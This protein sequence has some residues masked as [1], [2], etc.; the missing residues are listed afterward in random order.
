MDFRFSDEQEM[1]AGVVR[2]LLADLCQ[3]ADLRRLMTSGEARDAQRWASLVELGLAGAQV[4]EAAGGLG[5]QQVDMVL[6]AE[7]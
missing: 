7:A 6:A 1:T 3:P 5:L 2:D 4:P